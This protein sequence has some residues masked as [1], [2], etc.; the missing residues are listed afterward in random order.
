MVNF[1]RKIKHYGNKFVIPYL[2]YFDDFEIN[3]P[4]S[5]HSSCLLGVY[6]SFPTAPNFIKY[7][8]QHI[9]IAALFQTADVKKFGN[10][11]CFITLIEILNDLE[12]NGIEI[13][14]KSGTKKIYFCLGLIVGDNVALNNILGFM[15]SFSAKFY[16]RTCKVENKDCKTSFQENCSKLRNITNYDYDVQLNDPQNT[17]LREF[18]VF[19]NI[20]NYHVTDNFYAD[21]LHDLFEG[22]L[23]YDICHIIQKLMISGFFDLE[24]LNIRKQ[25][26]DFGETENGNKSPAIKLEHLRSFHLKMTAREMMTFIHFFPLIVGDLVDEN[27]EMWEFLI[28]FIK[29]VNIL[30]LTEFTG[31][32]LINL[33]Q[34]VEYHHKKYVELFSD[35]L[36]PKHHFLLHYCRILDQSG[37]LKLLWTFNFG[38]KHRQLKSYTKNVMCRKNIQFSLGIKFCICFAEFILNFNNSIFEMGC[39]KYGSSSSPFY[40]ELKKLMKTTD[41]NKCTCFQFYKTC[42]TIYKKG[43]VVFSYAPTFTAYT[44]REIFVLNDDIYF[45]CEVIEIISFKNHFQSYLVNPSSSRFVSLRADSI[46]SPPIHIIHIKGDCFL[47]PKALFA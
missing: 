16:C 35:S 14:I 32:D 44:I 2:L 26:F 19:N 41:L 28:N 36:K 8:L 13:K 47:R 39:E 24:L 23:Q 3:N 29:I 21:L 15:R 12:Q 46:S 20:N 6:C 34:Y 30:L 5:P 4:L 9:F 25:N 10:D 11:R 33:Q 18:S 38:S 43:F 37:P 42:G 27:N 17:G 40:I 1:G 31:L 7:K 45:L 22:V